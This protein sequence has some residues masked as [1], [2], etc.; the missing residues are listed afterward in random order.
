MVDPIGARPV[1]SDPKVGAVAASAP[2]RPVAAA[3]PRDP[4]QPATA[5]RLHDVVSDYAKTPPVDLDRVARI[6]QAIA[7][8]DYPIAPETLADRLIALKLNWSPHDPS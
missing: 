3:A 4:D 8:G 6:R 2:A 5:S 1:A 7:K